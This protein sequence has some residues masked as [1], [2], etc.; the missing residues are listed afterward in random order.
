MSPLAPEAPT[1]PYRVKKGEKEGKALKA[2]ERHF[3]HGGLRQQDGGGALV[4]GET[5]SIK[6]GFVPSEQGAFYSSDMSPCCGRGR[7]TYHHTVIS[8]SLFLPR[9][10]LATFGKYYVAV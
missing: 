9:N 8:L 10:S 7:T 2:L 3:V 4:L 5:C 1:G 6:T